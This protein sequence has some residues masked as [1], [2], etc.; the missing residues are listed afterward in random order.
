MFLDDKFFDLIFR[1]TVR[2]A[3]SKGNSDFTTSANEIRVF[4]GILNFLG[5][6]RLYSQRAYWSVDEDLGSDL[7]KQA[8]SR[9]RFMKIKENIH[10]VDTDTVQSLKI[11]GISR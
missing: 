5:Y 2:Y 8:M 6:I 1:E 10:F 7:V 4:V 11:S 9:N 3:T